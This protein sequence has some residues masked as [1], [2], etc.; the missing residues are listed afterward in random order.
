MTRPEPSA[1][2]GP[3]RDPV[4]ELAE[5]FVARYRRGERPSLTEFIERAPEHADEIRELFPG[6]I[7]LEQASPASA[8]P[9][10]GALPAG[11]LERL[12]DYR[13]IREIGRGGMGIVY[14]AEQEALGRHV[15]LKVL[16]VTGVND[17]KSVLRF[18]RE[19]RAAARLHHTN[20]VPVFDVGERDGIHYYAMQFIR[21][22]GLDDVIR[23]LRR[24]RDPIRP[25]HAQP[26][27]PSPANDAAILA[28]SLQSGRFPDPDRAVH[29]SSEENAVAKTAAAVDRSDS[30]PRSSTFRSH[31]DSSRSDLHFFRSVA[32]VGQQVA[33]ALAY[34]HG[35]GVLHRDIK[36]S[37]LL[38]EASGTVWV[39]D[40]GLAKEE[41]ENLTRTGDVVGTLRYLAPERFK[42]HS[43]ARSDIYS[44]GL[45]LY[46]LITLRPAFSETDRVQLVHAIGHR[47]PEPPRKLEP[48]VPRDLETIVLKA[49]AKEP[50]RRYA[51]AE[52]LEEDLSRFLLDRPIAAR[53]ASGWERTWRW[54]RRNPLSAS[55]AASL[56]LIV[57]ASVVGLTGLYLNAN[58]QRHRAEDAEANWKEAAAEARQGEAASRQAEANAKAVLEFF[59]KHVLAAPRPPAN[60]RGTGNLPPPTASEG[61]TG[62]NTTIRAAVDRAEKEITRSFENQPLVE[63]SIRESLGNTYGFLEQF[64]RAIEQHERALALRKTHL[65]ADDPETMESRGSLAED[66]QYSGRPADALKLNEE[67]LKLRK[68]RLGP[69]HPRT[70]KTMFHLGDILIDLGRPADAAG[71]YEELIPLSRTKLA[72]DSE[73]MVHHMTSLAKA[74]GL[75]GR[76]DDATALL[77]KV[78]E[79][80]KAKYPSDDWHPIQTMMHLGY[81]KYN[82]GRIADALPVWDEAL[83]KARASLGPDAPLTLDLIT[84]MAL[85]YWDSGRLPE[86]IPLFEESLRIRKANKKPDKYNT[87]VTA[88][89]LAKAYQDSGRLQEALALFQETLK[90]AKVDLG[91]DHALTLILMNYTATSLLEM[92]KPDQAATLLR[93]CLERRS[94]RGAQDWWLFLTKSQL[95]QALTALKKY[96]EAEALLHEAYAGLMERRDKMF[97]RHHRYI[98]EAARSLVNLYESWGKKDQAASWRQKIAAQSPP[99]S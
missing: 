36:P 99:K 82:A 5:D 8:S 66:Y 31:A 10:T 65:G 80:Q 44:L 96:S 2:I 23:E 90:G 40:F 86:A 91:A 97:V 9:A 76:V 85:A 49:I 74:Y 47:D 27:Q 26:P 73:E 93:E 51:R 41:G 69:D 18:R 34:A 1:E 19:A 94:K 17:P 61:G 35:Q 32:R 68:A 15:A 38:L 92:K 60:E 63:A 21:G 87:L 33:S 13:V 12:G 22:Q 78:L 30:T 52:E 14:E 70:L 58:A 42:S 62:E 45:T 54:C 20:I 29:G 84:G 79:L 50:A 25:P 16:P 43:D 56:G 75:V 95:G 55:L 6:L 89:N 88:T 48:H 3:A 98:G 46:E 24:R 71:V 83:R 57:V 64:P 77:E 11:S 67:N 39:T 81:L 53:R 37:N 59:E 7:M 72:P 4:E 28:N